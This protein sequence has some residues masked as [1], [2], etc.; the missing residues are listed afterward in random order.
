[1]WW[2][3]V[4]QLCAIYTALLKQL[5]F[6]PIQKNNAYLRK[7][8]R[9]II[10]ASCKQFL[11]LIVLMIILALILRNCKYQNSTK[12]DTYPWPLYSGV[13]ISTKLS[14]VI[15]S[16]HDCNSAANPKIRCKMCTE[17]FPSNRSVL[18]FR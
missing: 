18:H 4:T 5:Q 10:G 17:F 1:M 9:K 3:S 6:I 15:Q 8:A 13:C 7:V 14:K 12:Y 16:V 11:T 2:L